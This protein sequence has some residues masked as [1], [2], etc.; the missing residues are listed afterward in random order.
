MIIKSPK[1]KG[2]EW[3]DYLSTPLALQ[4]S[5]GGDFTV[6]SIQ[7]GLETVDF[8]FVVDIDFEIEVGAVASVGPGEREWGSGLGEDNGVAC[9]AWWNGDLIEGVVQEA[10]EE[11]GGED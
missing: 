11:E 5:L 7:E 2:K 1:L 9:P 10:S 3:I 6:S 4:A 8:V